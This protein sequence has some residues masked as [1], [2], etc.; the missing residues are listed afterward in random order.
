MI[1][2]VIFDLDDTLYIERDFFRSGFNVVAAKLEARGFGCASQLGDLL[3]SIFLN[4]GRD[5]VFDKAS[6]RLAF[7]KEWIPELVE[8]FRAHTPLINLAPDAVEIL[9]RLRPHYRLGCITDGFADVQRRKI[10]VLGVD[11][12][13]DVVVVADDFGRK[14]WKPDPLP[15]R[16][17]CDRL[18][19]DEQQAIYIGD[20]TER[21][22]RGARNAGIR[23]VR[24]RRSGG[25]FSRN[26]GDLQDRPDFEIYALSELEHILNVLTKE[27]IK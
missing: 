4:E 10:K 2:A 7:P 20:N 14:H 26:D 3:E 8:T 11:A 22:M 9:S 27:Q 15:F 19:I 25:Y 1:K 5:N 17:C 24:L 21:D 6:A 18:G 13:L 16:M 12:L 23:S